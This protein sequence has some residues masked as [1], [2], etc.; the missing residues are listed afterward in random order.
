MVC[1]QTSYKYFCTGSCFCKWP[2]DWT[3]LT[4]IY[5]LTSIGIAIIKIK[6]AQDHLILMMEIPIY[7]NRWPWYWN[8]AE[9]PNWQ[10][11]DVI[12]WKHFP[13][14]WPFVNSP[15]KGQWRGALMFSLICVWINGWVN[16]H[17][18]VDL[19]CHPGHY[20]VIVMKKPLPKP[21]VIH[22]IFS[23]IITHRKVDVRK[24]SWP[25]TW[26]VWVLIWVRQRWDVFFVSPLSPKSWS[27]LRMIKAS[28]HQGS[29]LLY[30]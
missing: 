6:Q 18:A 5:H 26:P 22:F 9:V 2:G 19:R 13:R 11:D 15:H 29:E 25:S 12:R 1:L 14:N 7:P 24:I 30:K 16:N 8:G 3:V 17:E 4:Q 28:L 27:K 10:H 23:S 20:D 21:D